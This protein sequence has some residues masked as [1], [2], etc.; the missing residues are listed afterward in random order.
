[1]DGFDFIVRTKQDLIDAVEKYGI[2][3]FFRNSLPG[4]SLEEH[5]DPSTWYDTS[6]DFWPCWEWK[7]DVIR[8]LRCGYG[9]FFEKKAAYVSVEWF[10]HLANYRRD[11]YDFDARYDDGLASFRDKTLFELVDRN[12]PVVSRR[13]KELGNYGKGGQKG[14]DTLMNR[15]QEQCYVIIDDFVYLQDRKGRPY[16]WGV[17]EYSTPERFMGAAFTDGVYRCKPRESYER[18]FEHLRA[19]NPSAEEKALR[20]FLR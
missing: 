11:G 14:F 1:M 10:C 18:L 2:V 3:P 9:K 8:T 15:L 4:F 20:K 12:A 5:A 7:G 17:A 13:L 6:E 16:G 19:L